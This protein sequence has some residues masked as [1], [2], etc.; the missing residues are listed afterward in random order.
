MAAEI[1]HLK[2]LYEVQNV[3]LQEQ[4]NKYEAQQEELAVVKRM[5][6]IMAGKQPRR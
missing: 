4:N 2:T 3:Q 6:V 5:V 1:E